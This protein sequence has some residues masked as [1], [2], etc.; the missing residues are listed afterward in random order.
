MDERAKGLLEGGGAVIAVLALAG[1]LATAWS[2]YASKDEELKV[3]L[4]E[5]AIGILR[6]DPTKEDVAGARGWAM[7]AIDKYSGLRPFTAAERDAL[8]HKPIGGAPAGLGFLPSGKRL[9]RGIRKGWVCHHT[10]QG[11]PGWVCHRTSGVRKGLVCHQGAQGWVWR[12][13]RNSKRSFGKDGV[14]VLPFSKDTTRRHQSEIM[15]VPTIDLPDDELAAVTAAIRRAI[16]DDRYPHAPRLDPLRAALARLDAA[17][18]EPTPLPKAPR[19]Q[20]RQARAAVN[21]R[22][23]GSGSTGVGRISR[24]V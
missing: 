3:H 24:R 15:T 2:A 5:I 4:V 7:D 8:L 22:K 6:A 19:G 12:L 1:V 13:T 20:G 17:A 10:P 23:G 9:V 21:L 11:A 14:E 16:A 18:A